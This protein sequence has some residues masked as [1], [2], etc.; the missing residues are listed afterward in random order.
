MTVTRAIGER[1]KGPEGCTSSNNTVQKLQ[2]LTLLKETIIF[3]QAPS[4]DLII[5]QRKMACY[6]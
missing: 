2:S 5:F 1:A 6:N 4:C 3:L